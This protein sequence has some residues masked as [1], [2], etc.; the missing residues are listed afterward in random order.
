MEPQPHTATPSA[1]EASEPAPGREP[2]ERLWLWAVLLVCSVAALVYLPWATHPTLRFSWAPLN[3]VAFIAMCGTVP[4]VILRLGTCL[5]WKWARWSLLALGSVVA[6]PA[7]LMMLVTFLFLL[8]P[9]IVRGSDPS[10]EPVAELSATWKD[11]RLYRTNGGA[12]TAFGLVLRRE[13]TVLPGLRVVSHIYDAYPAAEGRL[14][15]TSDTTGRLT[16]DAYSEFKPGEVY[17]FAL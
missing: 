5:R 17:D 15:R 8:V 3:Y 6:I 10:F 11:Y 13:V 9:T 2:D 14:T 4:A 7:S 1:P 16:I 12:T